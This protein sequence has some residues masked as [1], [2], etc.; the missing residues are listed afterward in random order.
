MHLVTVNDQIGDRGLGVSTVDSNAKPVASAARTI[1]ALKIVL[2][3]MDVVPQQF[4]MGARSR[5]ADSQR[6]EP[7]FGGSEVTNFKALD[8][9]I[10]LVVNGENALSA[11]GSEMRCVEDGRFARIASKS[12]ESIAR[13][14]GRVDAHQFFIDSA[15]NVDGATRPCCFGCMLNCAPRRGLRTRIRIIPGRRHVEGGVCLA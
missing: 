14:A 11:G 6:S 15:A 10:T 4:Y 13:I 12:D 8:P 7:M 3:V 5:H 9:Y 1:A 2:N